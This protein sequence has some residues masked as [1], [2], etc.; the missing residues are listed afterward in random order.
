MTSEGILHNRTEGHG[1]A[2]ARTT[3]ADRELREMLQRYLEPLVRLAGAQGGAVRV[4]SDAN[5]RLQVVGNLGRSDSLCHA[6]A[7]VDRHCGFCGEAADGSRVVW[8][9]DLSTCSKSVAGQR[10]SALDGQHML[11]LPLRHRARVLG[12]C[13]LFFAAGTEPAR[14]AL[15][16]LESAGDLLGLALDNARLE[17]ESFRLKLSHERQAMAAEV[18]DSLAQSLTFVK[19]RM[20]LLRDALLAHDDL[21]SLRYFEDVRDAVNQAHSGLRGVLTQLRSPPDP[22]GLAH[23]L[24]AAVAAF[25]QISSTQLEFVNEVPDMRLLPIDETEVFHIVQEALINVARH[26]VARR[27]SLR[28]SQPQPE[29]TVIVIEDDGAGLPVASPGGSHYG[30]EIMRERARRL[31]GT[32]EIGS[33]EGSGTRVRLAFAN[34]VPA[35][36]PITELS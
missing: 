31:G 1:I 8:A 17:A 2:R 27:A 30:L 4:L 32:L 16:V 19:M 34:R 13:N 14:E 15:A 7:T 26:A 5:D 11:T 10:D 12:V 28:V 20:P 36:A 25:R 33:R 3:D 18:H 24:D 22:L 23:A 29:T 9:T 21:R 35:R 6:G